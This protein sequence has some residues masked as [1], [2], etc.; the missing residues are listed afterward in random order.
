MVQKILLDRYGMTLTHDFLKNNIEMY[1]LSFQ[2]EEVFYHTLLV[3]KQVEALHKRFDF[4][5]EKCIVGAYLHDI[6]RVIDKTDLVEFCRTFGYEPLR[7][8][9]EAPGLLHQVASK[10]LATEIFGVE[11]KEILDALAYHT[12]LKQDP[13]RTDM[14]VFLADKLSWQ[15]DDYRALVIDMHTALEH[16]LEQSVYCYFDALHRKRASLTY[17]HKYS[18][19]AYGYLKGILSIEDSYK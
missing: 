16:S 5:L 6:G 13:T 2:K 7:G 12:T 8:E 4:D 14:V 17:Y 3:V 11:D 1:L 15:E 10:I 9:Q 19:E 18:Q